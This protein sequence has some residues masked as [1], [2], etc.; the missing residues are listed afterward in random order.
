MGVAAQ[1]RRFAGT[2]A[3]S[4][5]L[6]PL[7]VSPD[8]DSTAALEPRIPRLLQDRAAGMVIAAFFAV[9]RE[10]GFGF[11]ESVYQRALVLELAARALRFEQDVA[12][13]VLYKGTKVG[14]HRL[15]LVVEGRLLVEVTTGPRLDLARERELTHL[16]RASACPAGLL[17]HFGPAA[18]FRHAERDGAE[19]PSYLPG[20]RAA[21]PS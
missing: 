16:L 8:A 21:R 19:I 5:V 10:L 18:A 6:S 14:H 11:A 13:N 15:G 4:P 7:V 12:V 2:P 20:Q 17:L 3:D 9:H 1:V